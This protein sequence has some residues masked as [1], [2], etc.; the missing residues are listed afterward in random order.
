MYT[1]DH[2]DTNLAKTMWHRGLKSGIRWMQKDENYRSKI[3]VNYK[4]K[5]LVII[6]K[7][8]TFYKHG[9]VTQHLILENVC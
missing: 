6:N 7:K 2:M 9:Y 4:Q 1:E 5:L 8:L 3:F